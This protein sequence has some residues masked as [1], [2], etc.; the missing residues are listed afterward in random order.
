M[1]QSASRAPV[2]T[3]ADATASLSPPASLE[4]LVDVTGRG[5]RKGAR[6]N[7]V[8]FG[9]RV[10]SQRARAERRNRVP[11]REPKT[12]QE[13][14]ARARASKGSATSVLAKDADTRTLLTR[15]GRKQTASPIR[16]ESAS[17]VLRKLENASPSLFK[18][19]LSLPFP[20]SSSTFSPV[21][22]STLHQ[23]TGSPILEEQVVDPK[24]LLGRTTDVCLRRVRKALKKKGIPLIMCRATFLTKKYPRGRDTYCVPL[25]RGAEVEGAAGLRLYSVVDFGAREDGK[26]RGTVRHFDPRK[27]KLSSWVY[28]TNAWT[29]VKARDQFLQA[30]KKGTNP[31]V[32]DC[33]KWIPEYMRPG[34][35][36]GT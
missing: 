4:E 32:K 22:S 7:G 20:H 10:V 17:Q 9:T 14:A 28:Y 30:V 11:K 35:S 15:V 8:G 18:D 1:S 27:L 24:K 25:G 16:G 23:L 31:S 13:T 6:R 21:P 29:K 19:S 3:R 36:I 33:R 12:P 2:L 5:V 26:I 34:Y